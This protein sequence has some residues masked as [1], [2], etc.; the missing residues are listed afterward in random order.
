MADAVET[1]DRC[2]RHEN[3]ARKRGLPY[4]FPDA[5][6]VSFPRSGRSWVKF[7]TQHVMLALGHKKFEGLVMFKHDG[8]GIHVAQKKKHYRRDKHK[9]YGSRR[10][11]L[12][13]RDPRD[14]VVSGYHLLRHRSYQERFQ[15]WTLGE[16]LRHPR[17]LEFL[18]EWMN[19]WA[20]QI[21]VPRD[22]L[23]LRY[24]LFLEDAVAELRRLLQFLGLSPPQMLIEEAVDLCSFESLRQHDRE[25]LMP[26][27]D[28]EIGRKL[29][30]KD[31]H[32]YA[33]RRGRAGNWREE[34]D[35]GDQAWAAVYLMEHLDDVYWFYKNGRCAS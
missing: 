32:A 20:R 31:E 9:L 21:H 26:G 17:G 1:I 14:V 19:D 22:F 4:F 2:R 5:R 13:V 6:F 34:L 23:L 15:R 28:R 3:A 29:D 16:Y 10:V 12:L 27:I 11:V 25:K 30:R 24:E 7:M 8:A 33:V 18:V 35:E